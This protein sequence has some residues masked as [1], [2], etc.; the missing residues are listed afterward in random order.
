MVTKF[1]REEKIMFDDVLEGFDDL[2]VIGKEATKYTPPGPQ[3]MVNYGD[4]FW[5]P[6]PMIGSSYDGFDQTANFDGLTELAVPVT[7]GFHKSSPKTLSSKNLRNEWAMRQYATAAK[8]KLASD[9][10]RSL[11]DTV[12]LQGSVV[13][14][15]TVAASGF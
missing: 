9:I 14:K 1:T 12:A 6:A 2:L 13:I 11:S 3:D 8:Q 15:R 5:L 10:N 4:R 7:V